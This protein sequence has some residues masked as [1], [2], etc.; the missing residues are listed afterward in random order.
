MRL[1]LFLKASFPIFLTP[2]GTTTWVT[3]EGH[4]SCAHLGSRV[5]FLRLSQLEKADSPMA[6][7]LRGIATAVSPSQL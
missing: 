2:E 4:A 3:E 6:V 7:T 1:L 5:I